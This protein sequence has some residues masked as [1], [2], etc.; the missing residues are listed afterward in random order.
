MSPAAEELPAEPLELRSSSVADVNQSQRIIEVIAAPYEE[1]AAVP[2]RG[3][4][5]QE[6]VYAR[7]VGWD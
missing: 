2:W 1:V 7:R 5:W 3:E 4:V 6:N